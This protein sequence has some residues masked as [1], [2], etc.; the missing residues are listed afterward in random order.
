MKLFTMEKELRIIK[1]RGYF[2]IPS[3][4][5]QG[6]K[7]ETSHDK[8]KVLEAVNVEVTEMVKAIRQSEENYERE[9]EQAKNK[10]EQLTRQTNRQDFNFLTL[11]N[12]TPIRNSNAR[13]DQPAIHFDTNT[14]RH[15]YPPTNMTTNADL[16]E[17][18]A[19]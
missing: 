16:Y 7:I 3:I 19:K 10:D 18:P 14:V 6:K 12:S 4:T 17:P 2:P 9:Q 5:P 13:T 8:V 11:I 1:N 15:F